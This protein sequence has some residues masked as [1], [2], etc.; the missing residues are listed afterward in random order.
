MTT[1]PDFNPALGAPEATLPTRF[2][3]MLERA[4]QVL[5]ALRREKA[6]PTERGLPVMGIALSGGG[7]RSATFSLGVLQGLAKL[8]L[9]KS[10]DYLSTVSGGGYIGGFLG[11]LYCRPGIHGR[12]PTSVEVEEGL[13]APEAPPSPGPN[14]IYRSVRWLRENGRYLTPGG[15]GDR[16]RAA[17]V[18]LRNFL[19]VH[20]VMGLLWLFLLLALDGLVSQVL[21]AEPI[22]TDWSVLKLQVYLSP[23]AGSP[24]L[25]FAAGLILFGWAYWLIP[26]GQAKG[27]FYFA[28]PVWGVLTL[29]LWVG[30]GYVFQPETPRLD[31]LWLFLRLLSFT[32]AGA[33]LL[34]SPYLRNNLPVQR[35]GR[36]QQTEFLRG[37]LLTAVALAFYALVDSLGW[38]FWRQTFTSAQLAQGDLGWLGGFSG[39]LR[40]LL[41]AAQILLH[42]LFTPH[43]ALA[44]AAA[45]LV[46]FRKELQDF[47]GEAKTDSLRAK[48]LPMATRSLVGIA[49]LGLILLSAG[50]FSALAHLISFGP[51]SAVPS[52]PFSAPLTRSD[53]VLLLG[54]L[55]ALVAVMSRVIGFLNWSTL[56]PTY[57]AALARAYLGAS[58]PMRRAGDSDYQLLEGDDLPWEQ[59]RPWEA[60]GPLHLINCTLN[61]TTGGKSQVTQKDRKGMNLALGPAALSVAAGHHAL[62]NASRTE[63]SG[64]PKPEGHS[65]FGDSPRTFAPEA[66]S[67]G[68]WVGISGAAASTGMGHYTSLATSLWMGLLNIRLGY[69]WWSGVTLQQG[70]LRAGLEW[71]LPVHMHLLEEWTARFPGSHSRHWYLSDGGHFENT[72]A[73]ELVRRRLPFIL[74]CDNGADSGRE[75]DDLSNLVQKARIDFAAEIR[76]LDTEGL[77]TRFQEKPIPKGLGS[78]EEL[79]DPQDKAVAAL[80]EV[81]YLD[82]KGNVASTGVILVLKPTLSPRLPLDIQAYHRVNGDFPQQSTADQFFDEAQWESYRRL[83]EF[84]TLEVLGGK[85]GHNPAA[86]F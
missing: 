20:V 75:L 5:I 52:K 28:W 21:K 55:L 31:S 35:K 47:A 50:L 68:Q 11:A 18:M 58:N 69:W 45:A 78:L 67:L 71:L 43:G 54:G 77:Q 32:A 6:M 64:I 84:I 85:P 24:L 3:D 70:A 83:G 2:P 80:A 42:K 46:Y 7:I 9:L 38:T 72:A 63:A 15:S 34:A 65:V 10:F 39:I 53:S 44:A 33:L 22:A 16:V 79:R 74:L 81:D 27:R 4:E 60:G 76:V 36:I 1:D 62:W 41:R 19:A 66:L 23:W 86:W 37:C 56:G 73:Y 26:Q 49:A 8:G 25:L 59:Y 14:A 13:A 30:I 12:P 57:T 40:N 29:W 82:T 61:E 17:G 48:L 51:A